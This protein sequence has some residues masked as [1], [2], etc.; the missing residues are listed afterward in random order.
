MPPEPR[1]SIVTAVRDGARTI[2][3]TIASVQAQSET[4]WEHIVVDDG[5]GDA[6]AATV[7]AAGDARL[8]YVQQAPAGR[9]AARNRGIELAR[10]S[11]LLFLDADDWL[12]PDALRDHLRFLDAHPEFGVGVSDGHF[13]T[14]DGEPIVAFSARS[15]PP[16]PDGTIAGLIT[17]PGLVAAPLAA[18]LRSAIVRQHAIRFDPELSVAEDTVFWIEVARRAAFG[19]HA[20]VTC[21]YR[22]HAGNTTRGMAPAE[23]RAQ[24]WRAAE[25]MLAVPDFPRLPAAARERF[26]YRALTELLVER[27]DVQARIIVAAPFVSLAPEVRARLLRL[28]ASELVLARRA[29]DFAGELL[30]QACSLAPRDTRAQ[31]LARL[32]AVHPW[33]ARL[34]VRTRRSAATAEDPLW[35]TAPGSSR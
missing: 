19:F 34:A 5:S 30:R 8:H 2:A 33:L 20:A 10:G 23:R 15:G 14:D 35:R 17:N 21:K 9:S 18:M 13:C 11:H 31:L 12:L 6:T 32:L 7:A 16:P 28:A 24:L 4:A 3:A 29:P 26:F 22:W 1:V 25:R 27:P